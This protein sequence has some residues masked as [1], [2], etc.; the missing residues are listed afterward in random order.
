LGNFAAAKWEPGTLHRN[1]LEAVERLVSNMAF[2]SDPHSLEGPRR[3]V[4]RTAVLKLFSAMPDLKQPLDTWVRQVRDEVRITLGTLT[5]DP[6]HKPEHRIRAK[7]DFELVTAAE[8]I[9]PSPNELPARTVHDVKGESHEAVLLVIQPRT[10]R[11][12]DQCQLWAAPLL[13]EEV[14]ESELEELR[15][16]YVA[17][18]RAE[19]YCAMAIP[20]NVDQ[21]RIEAYTAAGFQRIG[22]TN[23]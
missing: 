20:N 3:E 9:A 4:L 21:H 1:E 6:V 14:E 22:P 11:Q 12:P 7:K 19:R 13:G 18:T 8:A 2:G 16:A 23:T 15:I 17:L 10:G 5:D